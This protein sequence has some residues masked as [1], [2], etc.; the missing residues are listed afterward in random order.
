[1]CYK[2][3]MFCRIHRSLQTI[4]EKLEFLELEIKKLSQNGRAMIQDGSNAEDEI[5][6]QQVA[7]LDEDQVR[8]TNTDTH[9]HPEK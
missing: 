2:V 4:L 9:L 3:M 7:R 5:N 6:R 1:M 8:I